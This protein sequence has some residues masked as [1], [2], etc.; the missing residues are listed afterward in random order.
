VKQSIVVVGGGLV[1]LATARALANSGRVDSVQVLEK[2]A[3]VA[4]HQSGRNSGVLH[5]GFHYPPGSARAQL[6]VEGL[7]RMVE[8]A[9][10]HG[11]GFQLCGKLVVAVS[12]D[13]IPRLRDLL[14]RGKANGLRGLRWL[15]PEE[16]GEIEP[17]ARCVAAVHVPEEGIIDYPAVAR[18]LRHELETSGAEV[19]TGCEV[20]GAAREGGA[21]IVK[22][23]HGEL[24]CDFVVN[25]AGL[26][27]DRVAVSMGVLTTNRIVPFRGDYFVLTEDAAGL[28]RGL[29]YPVPDPR[30]PFLGVHLTRTIMGEVECGPS[31]VLA[32]SR[33]GYRRFDFSLRDTVEALSFSGLRKFLVRHPAYVG[34]EVRQA[35]SRKVFARSAARLVPDLK[36][37]DLVRGPSGVRAQAMDRKGHLLDDFL[38]E[39]GPASL[40]VLNAP[41]PAATA[42]LSIGERIAHQ[43]LRG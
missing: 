27:S 7:R 37:S 17:A 4:L 29:I 30:F 14:A 8:Y 22:S 12:E 38:F 20:F 42:S 34:R 33:E 11:V 26:H 31:A 43:V 41:S 6:A 36:A 32:L 35:M 40:H 25:C 15:S 28:V 9:T 10:E 18:A 1:G 3:D 13:E 19:R 23:S 24:T 16:A 21:W 39:P 5:A 2:E